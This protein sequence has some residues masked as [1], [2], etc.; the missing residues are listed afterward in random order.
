MILVDRTIWIIIA[1][2]KGISQLF[3]STTFTKALAISINILS[4]Q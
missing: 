1:Y 2:E 4:K 3:D